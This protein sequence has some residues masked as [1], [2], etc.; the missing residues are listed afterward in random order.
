VLG[1]SVESLV[2][3][4]IDRRVDLVVEGVHV[5]PSTKLIQKW[6][7]AGGVATGCILQ[8]SSPETHKKLLKKRGFITGNVENE[9]K[10]INSYERVREIQDDMM[11]LADESGWL[12][13]EQRTEPDPLEMVASK[14]MGVSDDV[15]NVGS[16]TDSSKN[17][18]KLSKADKV[19]EEH[20]PANAS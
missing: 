19:A 15:N 20:V 1:A 8:V 13:I 3:D 12:R 14:L 9:E 11:R 6:E 16:T 4:A 2:D 7:E 5:V 10:K 17:M 18:K